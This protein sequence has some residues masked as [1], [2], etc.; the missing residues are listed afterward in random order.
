MTE[1]LRTDEAEVAEVVDPRDGEVHAM[2]LAIV[3]SLV[4]EPDKVEL[5]RI[6]GAAGMAFQVRSA[7]EDVGKLIGKGGRTARAIRVILS[8]N[9]AKN[10]RRY[11]L[12]IA[13]VEPEA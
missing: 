1:I 4:S 3:R 10:G 12:D 6:A 13:R 11:T 7:V 5:L 8:G 9:A 2:L